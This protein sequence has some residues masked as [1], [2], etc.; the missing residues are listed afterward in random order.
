VK[1]IVVLD[2]NILLDILVF[3][4][5]RA[6]PLRNALTNS[7]VD[8]VATQ[9]TIDEFIDVIGRV[10]FELSEQQ[11]LEIANQWRAW[12]RI[13][14]DAQ[15]LLAPWKCKDRD[16]QIFIN[17]AYTL[18]PSTLL[19]KDKQVLKIAKRAVKESVVITA[20]HEKFLVS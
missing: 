18:R 13:I 7:L 10:Q 12:A 3:D 1:P 5:Q 2:T 4:D 20:N 9:R 17:L 16:D 15:V 8:A 6:H 14:D 11:Q 19:S